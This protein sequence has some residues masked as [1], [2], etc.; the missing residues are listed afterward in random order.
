[1]GLRVPLTNSSNL[2]SPFADQRQ[3]GFGWLQFSD[4]VEEEFRQYY[5]QS[6]VKQARL[7]LCLAI[8]VILIIMGSELA[9]SDIS[10]PKMTFNALILLPT[11][12]GALFFSTKPS[13]N[14]TYQYLLLI[15]A[16][17]IGLQITLFVMNA[18]EMELSYFF[19]AEIAWIF[20]V[21][22][23]LGLVIRQAAITALTISGAYTFGVFIWDIG[24]SEALFGT[25]TL[26]ACNAIG[27]YCCYQL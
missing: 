9:S 24:F 16:V 2:N 3:R 8:S 17:L 4:F 26:V 14:N 27:A 15:S 21:W 7:A 18:S 20:V 13:Q 11:L 22:L 25:M 12:I 19:A 10:Y 5:A 23:V 6:G 1:M